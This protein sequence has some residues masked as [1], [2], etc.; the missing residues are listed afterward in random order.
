MLRI[1]PD[2]APNNDQATIKKTFVDPAGSAI[3]VT[4]VKLFDGAAE[5]TPSW[6]TY[7]QAPGDVLPGGGTTIDVTMVVKLQGPEAKLYEIELTGIKNGQP[8]VHRFKLDLRMLSSNRIF[9]SQGATAANYGI[10]AM[11]PDGVGDYKLIQTG[12][13]DTVFAVDPLEGVLF[14]VP[15]QGVV[16]RANLDGSADAQIATGL[17]YVLSLAVDKTNQKLYMAG[18]TGT[19]IRRCNYNGSNL[20]LVVPLT[21]LGNY[22]VQ[23]LWIDVPE[24]MIYL[25]Y[26]YNQAIHK[27]PITTP[28][29]QLIK[30]SAGS[31]HAFD[32][33]RGRF[34]AVFTGYVSS[35]AFDGTLI[36]DRLFNGNIGGIAYDAPTDKLLISTTDRKLYRCD[37]DGTDLEQ[38][39]PTSGAFLSAPAN[40]ATMIN[41]ALP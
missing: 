24:D 8:V 13:A 25:Y 35:F 11:R 28:S 2:P 29:L 5:I 21:L 14:Y 16:R 37:P 6:W 33:A 36:K 26:N 31:K 30:A 7:T 40:L 15:S 38:I 10:Y 9:F 17:G 18:H 20:E 1:K 19:G 41:P 22:Y 34:F 3:S 4:S 12:A 39:T 32:V 27:T 23:G